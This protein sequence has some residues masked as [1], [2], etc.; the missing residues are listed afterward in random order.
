[1][2]PFALPPVAALLAAL[3]DAVVTLAVALDP[4]AGGVA[5]AVAIAIVTVLVRILMIPVGI[6][7]ARAE[8]TRRR[9]A[10]KLRVL[11]QRFASDPQQFQRKAAA[12]YREEHASPFAGLLPLLAQAPVISLVYALFIRGTIG[13]HANVLLAASMGGVPMSASLMTAGATWPALGFFGALLFVLALTAW[14]SRRA[15]LH[16]SVEPATRMSA[17]LSWMPFAVLIVGAVVPL[18]AGVYLATSA[19]WGVAE[20]AILR[21]M[22]VRAV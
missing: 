12:L 7:H 18:A 17:L 9:L 8:N 10:P 20:R 3:H 13:G 22:L 19:A 4:L 5:T 15:A 14:L 1:M 2:D 6:S 11:R 16:A 21:R